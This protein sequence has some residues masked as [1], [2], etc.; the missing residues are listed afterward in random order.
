MFTRIPIKVLAPLLFGVPVLA[1]GLWLSLAWNHQ[2]QR[3]ITRLADQDIEQIHQATAAKIAD[4]LSVPVRVCQLNQHLITSRKLPPDNLALW[5]PTFVRESQAFEMLS[6][7]SWGSVDGRAAWVSRYADGNIYWA[8]KEDATQPLMNQWKLDANGDVAA[9]SR[10]SFEFLLS[11]RPWFKTPSEARR[12]TWSEPYLWV[13]GNDEEGQT[14]GISYGIPLYDGKQLL[15]VID[16]D[17]SLNDLSDYLGRLKFGKTGMALLVSPD[18]KLLAASN[19]TPIVLPNGERALAA[20]STSPLVAT[21]G[22]CLEGKTFVNDSSSHLTVDGTTFYLHASEVGEDV[23]LNWTLVTIVP[24]E[25]FIGDIQTEFA[26]SWATSLV[27][28]LLAIGLGFI[29]ARWLVDPLTRIV[30]SVRRIGQGDL[31]TRLEMQHAPEYTQLA[32]AI[33][34]MAEGLQDRMRMQKSLSLAMEVQRNLLP[35]EAPCF[36]GLDVAGHSTYCDETGGDYFDFLDVS[37]CDQDTAVIVIGD[38]MGHGVAAALLM[39]TARGILRSRCAVPG[40]L[41]DFLKHLN[42]MLVV[43]TQGERFMTMLL[44]NL[45]AKK[46]TLRWASAGHGP[47][48]LYMPDTDR[49]PE[50][51]GGGLP[52][53]L[54]AG[55]TYSEYWQPG[56]KPGTILL[57]TTDGLEETMNEQGQ[58]FGKQ[59][60]QQL[61][62]EHATQSAEEISQAI[63]QSLAIFRGANSQDDDLTFVVA[64]VL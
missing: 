2:S 33:N 20:E 28:V 5:R 1:I 8:L 16:A 4:V 22:K 35:T 62:R 7:I 49:F 48:I 3:A 10:S 30:S 14:L 42:E 61:L 64:K 37:G 18:R 60:L 40:S 54:V 39:A 34:T 25:D 32:T 44:V 43:D 27:A 50:F 57:A 21:V 53:G 23:G 13:G 6:A 52:L 26:R 9:G 41:A 56:I 55:E 24:E 19:D 38:V 29:A 51:D 17:F 45:S 46:D 63:R 36:N 59:R 47:P 11:T 31:D 15:G 12:A 58:Q